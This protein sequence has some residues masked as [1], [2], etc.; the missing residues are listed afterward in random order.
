MAVGRVLSLPLV[1][2]FQRAVFKE[3]FSKNVLEIII[4]LQG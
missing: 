1:H 2:C 3:L 4:L